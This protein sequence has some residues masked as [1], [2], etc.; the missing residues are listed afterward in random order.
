LAGYSDEIR[1]RLLI[2]VAYQHFLTFA[3]RKRQMVYRHAALSDPETRGMVDRKPIETTL[4]ALPMCTQDQSYGVIHI[5]SFADG[6][7]EID[8]ADLRFFSSL[9]SF[10][11]MALAN[12]NVFLQTRSE[13]TSTKQLSERELAEKKKLKEIFGRYT[14][15][16][17]V[18]TILKNPSS[19]SLGGITKEATILFSDIAGFTRFSAALTPQQVVSAM[20]EYLS[21]MTE[22][23]LEHKG[24]IDKFIG[25]AVMARFGVLSDLTSPGLAAVQAALAMLEKLAELQT[26]WKQ[27]GRQPFA[28]RIGIASGPVLAGNIGSERRQEFTVMGSTVNL[29]SRLE[30]LN[31]E[32]KT[33]ILIDE[34]TYLQTQS[35]IEAKVHDQISIRGFEDQSSFRVFEVRGYRQNVVVPPPSALVQGEPPPMTMVAPAG[36]Q[37]DEPQAG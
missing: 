30:S 6:R 8:D 11:G 16:E 26:S 31:K 17:L 34:Q 18:D 22:V 14:S 27:Q 3:F 32:L 20:N 2:P 1:N 23:V 13:L 19:I 10:M 28:I 15:S 25:D 33:T 29:A 36:E 4:L 9:S 12:S 24:E 35:F 7:M 37:V 21:A 5:E